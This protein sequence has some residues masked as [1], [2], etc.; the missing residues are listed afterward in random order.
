MSEI[1]T[2]QVCGREIKATTGVIAHHGYKRPQGWGW[3]TASCMGARHLPYEESCEVLK[4]AITE[5]ERYIAANERVLAEL[6]AT[7]PA[8]MWIEKP[9]RGSKEPREVTRPENFNSANFNATIPD[10]YENAYG[11]AKYDLERDIRAA[12]GQLATMRQ[13]LAAWVA[14]AI[15]TIEPEEETCVAAATPEPVELSINA[16]KRAVALKLL[17][18]AGNLVEFWGE[19]G[20]EGVGADEAAEMLTTWLQYLPGGEWD[21]RL[22]QP[23]K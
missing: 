21:T 1:K 18:A 8:T 7:P 10:T 4:E 15:I 13:R 23:K 16:K 3:Q 12:E 17:G 19:L 2:C 6:V 20:V 22:P 11:K 5:V 14:P 9:W